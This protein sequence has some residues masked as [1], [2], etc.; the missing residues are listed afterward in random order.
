MRSGSDGD[1]RLG[2]VAGGDLVEGVDGGGEFGRAL[3]WSGAMSGRRMW[4]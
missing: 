3:G 4:S 1:A 2:D